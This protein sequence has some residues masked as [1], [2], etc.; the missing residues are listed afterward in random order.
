MFVRLRQRMQTSRID[1]LQ[2]NIQRIGESLQPREALVMTITRYV[3]LD[4][5]F[6]SPLKPGVDGVKAHD[7][8]ELHR[9]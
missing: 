9:V 2:L 7:S 5:C 3:E 6:R 4:H 8:C 1:N